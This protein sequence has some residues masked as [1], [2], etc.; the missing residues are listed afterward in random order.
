MAPNPTLW[1]A[2]TQNVMMAALNAFPV[3]AVLIPQ[4]GSGPVPI[5]CIEMEDA[6]AENLYPGVQRSVVKLFV[7]IAIITPAPQAGDTVT[8]NGANYVVTGAPV[9]IYGG[10]VLKLR[11]T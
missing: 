7:N 8:Y 2:L 9:D 6:T 1:A 11:I 4:T 10:A 3:A 5:S